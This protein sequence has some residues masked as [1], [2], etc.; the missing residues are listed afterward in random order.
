MPKIET[1][2]Q[3]K[4]RCY[5]AA[6][7]ANHVGILVHSTGAVNKNQKRY[8]DAPDLVGVNVNGN[9]WNNSTGDKCMHAFIGLDK[10]GEVMVIQTLPY[11]YA[12]WGCG[13]GDKGSYNYDPTA[14]IQ[15]EICQGSN[16]DAAYYRKAIAAAEEYCA[17]LCRLFGF[18]S[19][20]IV[21][22]KEA[23]RRGYASKHD[24]PEEWMRCFGDDMN[25]FRARVAAKLADGEEVKT[26]IEYKVT[27]TRL[28]LRTSPSTS[29]T[30]VKHNGQ[31][32]RMPTGSIVVGE[33]VNADWA[34]ITYGNLSGYSMLKYLE[35]QRNLTETENNK[36]EH[37]W[38][39][40]S[41]EE[42]LDELLVRIK[43]LEG[44]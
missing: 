14:H 24:D 36:Q 13:S 6:K 16:T 28:A 7:K 5:K 35:P 22:H 38:E 44:G 34:K 18:T 26:M 40:M 39:T 21:S 17:R 3:T 8:V 25:Q 30:L 23:G 20:N 2:Y 12:C 42:K 10:A 19:D 29:A 4:N 43:K 9:H 41:I 31:D 11:D 33:A 1:V 27:G 37:L 15:F 32:I